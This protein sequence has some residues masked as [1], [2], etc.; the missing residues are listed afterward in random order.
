MQPNLSLRE[1]AARIG[2]APLTLRRMAVYQ[3]RLPYLKV[4][5]KLVFRLTDLE[6]FELSCLIPRRE[7]G[8]R[9]AR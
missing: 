6:T 8:G 1:A 3:G 7:P 9:P 5:R 4:G 2:V